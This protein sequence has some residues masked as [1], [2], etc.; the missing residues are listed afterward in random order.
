MKAPPFK[1]SDLKDEYYIKLANNEKGQFWE[2]FAGKCK[3]SAEFKGTFPLINRSH[4][5]VIESQPQRSHHPLVDLQTPM[6]SPIDCIKS[7]V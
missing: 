2:I 7:L 6:D 3:P 4:R 5:K 1:T